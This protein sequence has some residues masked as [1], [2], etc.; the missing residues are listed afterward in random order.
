MA[1][2]RRLSSA[3]KPD[4]KRP[5]ITPNAM[6]AASVCIQTQTKDA[7]ARAA[8]KLALQDLDPKSVRERNIFM[9]GNANGVLAV[10]FRHLQN[11][12]KA[13][14]KQ[15][16]DDVVT[17]FI[18]IQAGYVIKHTKDVKVK[19]G[20]YNNGDQN[21]PSKENSEIDGNGN[22]N[23][24]SP[25]SKKSPSKA[26]NQLS[27]MAQMQQR[28]KEREIME[29]IKNSQLANGG[30]FDA[31]ESG[32][33]IV[34]VDTVK[35]LNLT[36][37]R[38][39]ED[40]ENSV[41]F[42]L[43]YKDKDDNCTTIGTSMI[44]VFE[45]I[46]AM[47]GTKEIQFQRNK[48]AVC[49]LVIDFAFRYGFYGYGYGHQLERHSN[50][51]PQRQ[52]LKQSLFPRVDP[53][54]FRKDPENL[55]KIMHVDYPDYLNLDEKS[56]IGSEY[57]RNLSN[58]VTKKSVEA[59]DNLLEVRENPY[60]R[61]AYRQRKS[62]LDVLGD[63]SSLEDEDYKRV[64]KI[65]AGEESKIVEKLINRRK[66]LPS[67]I[68]DF[69]TKKTRFERIQY[70]EMIL[71]KRG[72]ALSGKDLES[73]GEQVFE[74]QKFQK[75]GKNNFLDI[76]EETDVLMDLSPGITTREKDSKKK[77]K[78]KKTAESRTSLLGGMLDKV[79]SML[80]LG[81]GK[82]DEE[83]PGRESSDALPTIKED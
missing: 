78:K 20:S 30:N 15:G 81:G 27:K 82:K 23:S 29:Q 35:N 63:D 79:G 36:V 14:F 9:S 43:V 64:Y 65:N 45:F 60:F 51:M 53:P 40:E 55:C 48:V 28:K 76:L 46:A 17:F 2:T 38:K 83:K 50:L 7:K 72:D 8:A 32:R 59:Q 69:N 10:H 37:N 5:S 16:F 77:K 73:L 41:F 68:R 42:H 34:G 66:K 74:A 56:E 3:Q 25:G 11:F 52:I 26:G 80:S 21:N 18:L 31:L 75:R 49:E 61:K 57:V 6:R 22:E 39:S 1:D 13:F 62:V 58:E 47:N 24:G 44:T 12:N 67:I 19:K 33:A 54:S 70:L 4:A 71:A